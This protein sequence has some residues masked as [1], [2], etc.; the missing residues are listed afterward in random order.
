LQ[1]VAPRR[2]SAGHLATSATWWAA[3]L[4]VTTMGTYRS[5]GRCHS[6][7]VEASAP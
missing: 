3:T 1:S 6:D 7:E 2:S 5:P 4:R